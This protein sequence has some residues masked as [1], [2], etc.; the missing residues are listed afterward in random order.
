[1]KTRLV[2]RPGYSALLGDG[3]ALQEVLGLVDLIDDLPGGEVALEA[4]AGGGAE[5]AG[6]GAADLRRDALG[7]AALVVGDEHALEGGALGGAQAQLAGAVVRGE[8][9]VDV[10][11]RERG[12]AGE[13][14]ALVGG[15]VGHD[16]EVRGP[17]LV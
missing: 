2:M 11:A 6:E 5:A 14:G 9:G 13:A 12:L 17:A 8:H 4:E 16:R 10:Q 7:V 3:L 15:E 1:M